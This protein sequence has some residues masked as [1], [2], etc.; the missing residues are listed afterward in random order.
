MFSLKMA[1]KMAE[2]QWLLK[3]GDGFVG[4]L[5]VKSLSFCVCVSIAWAEVLEQ[6]GFVTCDGGWLGCWMLMQSGKYY[7]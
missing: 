6:G 4:P 2:S 3:L 5:T 7:F 1:F